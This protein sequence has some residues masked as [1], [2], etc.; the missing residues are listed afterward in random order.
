MTQASKKTRNIYTCFIDY[1]KAFDMVPHDWL[2]NTLTTYRINPVIVH[3]LKTIMNKWC[4]TIHI[5]T[6]VKTV[7]TRTLDIKRGIFQGD[8]LSPFWFCLA[9][10]PLSTL[11]DKNGTGFELKGIKKYKVTHL[12]YMDDIKLYSCSKRGLE[13]LLEITEMFSND[14]GMQLGIDKCKIQSVRKGKLTTDIEYETVTKETITAVNTNEFY[15]YLGIQQSLTIPHTKIK[16][17]LKAEFERRLKAVLK[18]HLN[19]KNLTTAINTYAIPVLTYSI[20]V[21][22]W[23]KTDID[24]IERSLRVQMTRFRYHHPR[25]CT[26]RVTLP[27]K[28]GGRGMVNLSNLHIRQ[29]TILR[30]YFGKKAQISQLHE[31]VQEA[32]DNLTPLSLRNDMN[33]QQS[34]LETEMVKWKQKAL[35]G[36][37]PAAIANENV[38]VDMSYKW[39]TVGYLFP[40]TEGLIIAIQD[41]VIPTKNYLKHIVKD[42]SVVDDNCRMCFQRS[43]TIQHILTGCSVLAPSEY[44]L[45]HDNIGRIIHAKLAEKYGLLHEITPYYKYHPQTVLENTTYKL[46]WDRSILTDKTVHHNRPDITIWDRVSK[47]VFFVDFAVVDNNNIMT[48]YQTKLGKYRELVQV[49]KEEWSLENAKTIPI[50]ISATGIVPKVTVK[51]VE[52]LDINKNILINMQKAVIINTCSLVRRIMGSDL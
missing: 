46:Y 2:I 23:T 12:A 35:H 33:Q 42:P 43:E 7:I 10:N 26:Q 49:V 31:V 48:T 14:I 9:M 38:D 13:K 19:S 37:Y 27:R 21:V 25:S 34:T 44:K 4:T 30:E 11:L 8:S 40:E 29:I 28:S 32:D 36:A 5:T 50:V 15:K 45:R 17:E 41:Q 24:A 3:F 51:S 6:N 22:K 47:K 52:E 20:G 39:L 16:E 1:K 18:T